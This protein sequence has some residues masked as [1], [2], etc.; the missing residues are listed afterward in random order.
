[1]NDKDKAVDMLRKRGLDMAN[2]DGVVIFR[3]PKSMGNKQ[4]QLYKS[5][6][7]ALQDIVYHASWGIHFV[8]DDKYNAKTDSLATA[9]DNKETVGDTESEDEE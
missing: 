7:K 8:D 2:T 6:K 3:Y 9:E 4:E 5:S 1:M